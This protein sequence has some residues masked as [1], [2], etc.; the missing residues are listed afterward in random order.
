M[1]KEDVSRLLGALA[2]V[3]ALGGLWFSYVYQALQNGFVWVYLQ[4]IIY[5]AFVIGT[6]LLVCLSLILGNNKRL[7]TVALAIVAANALA[8]CVTPYLPTPM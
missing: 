5:A 6:L 4:V 3:A 2:V 7:V 8:Y 1:W